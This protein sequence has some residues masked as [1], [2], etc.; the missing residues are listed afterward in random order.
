MSV[1]HH[2]HLVASK[3]LHLTYFSHLRHISGLDNVDTNTHS[4]KGLSSIL[5]GQA[6]LESLEKHLA[7]VKCPPWGHHL[8]SPFGSHSAKSSTDTQPCYLA[9]SLLRDIFYRC[10]N[11]LIIRTSKLQRLKILEDVFIA[12]LASSLLQVSQVLVTLP[13][14]KHL[15][16]ITVKT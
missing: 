11:I 15:S 14:F 13:V 1:L 16:H 4:L 3:D 10:F 7:C 5:S 8:G 9:T 6:R 12:S 2:S